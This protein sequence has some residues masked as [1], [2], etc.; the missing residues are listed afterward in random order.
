M[1]A[2][3]EGMCERFSKT[4]AKAGT[5]L[6]Y[7][8]VH[9]AT[10]AKKTPRRETLERLQKWSLAAIPEFNCYIS[11]IKTLRLAEPTTDEITA[12]RNNVLKVG[13]SK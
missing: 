13:D 10:V 7:S 3:S 11:A 1:A 6:S 8:A 9:D 2:H 12:L 4:A 5:S